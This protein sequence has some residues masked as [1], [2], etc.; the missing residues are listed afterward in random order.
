M[1]LRSSDRKLPLHFHAQKRT[2]LDHPD[3][4][5]APINI[6]G[7]LETGLKL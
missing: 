6:S 5:K 4:I 3:P 1:C 2:S 7:A